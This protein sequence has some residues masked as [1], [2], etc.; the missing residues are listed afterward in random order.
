MIGEFAALG[1]AVSWAVAPIL[2]RQALFKTRPISANVVRCISNSAVLLAL[3]LVVGK[4]GALTSLPFEAIGITV[5]SGLIG[6]G[7]GDTLY[8]VGLKSVGVSRAVP[9]ASTYPLFSLLWA[10]FLL[11][12]PVTLSAFLGALSIL[13]GIL[14]LSRGKDKSTN[15]AADNKLWRRGIVLSLA[16]AVVWSVSIT[17]MDVAVKLPGVNGSG[18]DFALITLRVS[19]IAV[20]MLALLPVLNKDRSLLKVSRNSVIALCV[21]G[22]VANGIGWFLM[23]IS[24]V[25]IF[26]SQAVPISSTTP[27]FSAMAGFVIFH[28]KFT[29]NSVL[30]AAAIV[31]GIF[32]IFLV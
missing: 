16:T 1:A 23:N 26:E 21:G 28:E 12:Q 15:S 22:L 24:F 31:L 4:L 18:A 20:L 30:G 7:I 3:L 10:T 11:G 9:L 13:L 6:L 25:N 27:L 8:M 2:Y 14:L 19:A 32:L 17:L 29:V 5:I